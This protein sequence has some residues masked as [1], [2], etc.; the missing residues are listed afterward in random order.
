MIISALKKNGNDVIVVFDDGTFLN[1]DY[2]IIIDSGL[3]KGDYLSEEEIEKL[4]KDN[5]FFKIRDSALRL[6]SRRFHSTTEIRTKLFKKKY[7]EEIILNVIANLKEKNYLDDDEFAKAYID[8]RIKSKRVGINRL[9]MELMKR[10]IDK[11]ITEKYLAK[12]NMND[13]FE[14]ALSIAKKKLTL[15]RRREIDSR[16]ISSKLFRFLISRGFNSD[17]CKNVLNELHLEIFE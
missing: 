14:N 13:Y 4:K 9:R 10:G 2:R 16:K 3:R 1:L 15:L 5:S 11:S 8:E 17:L 6:L 7:P 12:I